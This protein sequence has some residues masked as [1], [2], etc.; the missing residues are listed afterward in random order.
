MEVE[1]QEEQHQQ[2]QRNC[3]KRHTFGFK[4]PI[5]D[6]RALRMG[7]DYCRLDLLLWLLATTSSQGPLPLDQWGYLLRLF[8]GDFHSRQGIKQTA[9]SPV[10]MMACLFTLCHAQMSHI[11]TSNRQHTNTSE[12]QIK[13]KKKEPGNLLGVLNKEESCHISRKEKKNI[14]ER[15]EGM[16]LLLLDNQPCNTL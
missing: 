8:Q 14:Q 10:P 2:R 13:Q 1:K 16:L 12:V 3:A 7:L 11:F 4:A 15:W 5:S 6:P 9:D